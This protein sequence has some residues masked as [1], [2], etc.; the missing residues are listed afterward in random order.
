MACVFVFFLLPTFW[1]KLKKIMHEACE[2]LVI[3]ICTSQYRVMITISLL[4]CWICYFPVLL[5]VPSS[6]SYF[7]YKCKNGNDQLNFVPPYA[8]F[9]KAWFYKSNLD[10]YFY[11]DPSFCSSQRKKVL[12]LL[13]QTFSAVIHFNHSL[14]REIPSWIILQTQ[15]INETNPP[16]TW[17]L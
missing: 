8:L 7:L 1:N 17:V 12:A 11:C 4:H 15:S 14:L 6:S 3:F 5:V 10:L 16:I 13:R 9:F 2:L